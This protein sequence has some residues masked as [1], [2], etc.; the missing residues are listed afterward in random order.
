MVRC[1]RSVE[2]V[3]VVGGFAAAG[4]LVERG[5]P[6]SGRGSPASTSGPGSRFDPRREARR[7]ARRR[8][9]RVARARRREEGRRNARGTLGGARGPRGVLRAHANARDERVAGP[10]HRQRVGRGGV[11]RRRTSGGR[12]RWTRGF[13]TSRRHLA[14]FARVGAR[15]EAR[16][17]VSGRLVF[18]DG[19]GA[20]RTLRETTSVSVRRCPGG[21][22]GR[23]TVAAS[24]SRGGGA[25]GAG[26]VSR[27]PSD[28]DRS[29]GPVRV[30]SE[31]V[32]N[33]RSRNLA[34]SRR[35]RTFRSFPGTDARAGRRACRTA[36][37]SRD[38]ARR[39]RDER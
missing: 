26:R 16:L 35:R 15:R 22:P 36:R 13:R 24:S 10:E 9:R 30:F 3:V 5:E 4:P 12:H 8:L 38:P 27:A 39:H 17:D 32:Q 33:R 19:T 25:R 11:G 1:G 14:G 2:M 31:A 7:G 18:R 6:R 20:H 37:A 29:F 34:R 28:E 21:H 23:W